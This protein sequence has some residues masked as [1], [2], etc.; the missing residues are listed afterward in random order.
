MGISMIYLT[1]VKKTQDIEEVKQFFHTQ[2][3][4]EL[5]YLVNIDLFLDT[6]IQEDLITLSDGVV[7]HKDDLESKEYKS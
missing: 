7:V 6:K 2:S 5:K 1:G 3:N 4:K